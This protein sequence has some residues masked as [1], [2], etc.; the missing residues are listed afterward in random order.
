L[1]VKRALDEMVAE[2]M[3]TLEKVRVLLYRH[4]EPA[5]GDAR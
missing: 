1:E 3:A 2:G 4:R 5:D